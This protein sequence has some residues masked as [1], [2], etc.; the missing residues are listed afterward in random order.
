MFDHLRVSVRRLFD[1]ETWWLRMGRPRWRTV[2]TDRKTT[3]SGEYAVW[4][5]ARGRAVRVKGRIVQW[6][7]LGTDVYVYDPPEI[8]RRHTHGPCLQLV[9]PDDKWF[10]LHWNRPCRTFT[11]SK[12][13]VEQMLWEALA[14]SFKD[15]SK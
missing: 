13:Y 6:S 9:R 10:Y 3:Y 12:E 14:V 1:A 5:P 7:G 4:D 15:H 11:E 2:V 8:L